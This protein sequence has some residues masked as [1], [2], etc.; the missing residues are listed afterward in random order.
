MPESDFARML[1]GMRE[2]ALVTRADLDPP[3]PTIVAVSPGLCELTGYAASELVG[4]N[5]R[6]FQGPLTNRAELDRLRRTCAAGERFIGEAINYRKDGSTYLLQ[7]AIAP[8]WARGKVT[9]FISLQRDISA[10]RDYAGPWM[11]AEKRLGFA[12]AA[13]SQLLAAIAESI[14]ILDKAA[15]SLDSGELAGLR[16]RLLTTTQEAAAVFQGDLQPR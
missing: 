11:D 13:V 14:A 9:H 2:P 5:P 12:L 8:V 1:E 10:L 6:L 16:V 7:W 15:Q 4:R 3:G